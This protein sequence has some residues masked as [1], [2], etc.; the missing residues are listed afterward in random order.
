[1]LFELFGSVSTSSANFGL[2]FIV[3]FDILREEGESGELDQFLQETNHKLSII[4]FPYNM[5]VSAT[6]Q[7]TEREIHT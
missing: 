6:I 4:C 7:G 2:R 3:L 5:Q 1:M